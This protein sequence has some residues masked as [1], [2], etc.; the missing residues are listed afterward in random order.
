MVTIK[1][2]KKS[3]VGVALGALAVACTKA[4]VYDPSASPEQ[5]KQPEVEAPKVANAFNFSTT[6]TVALTIDYSADKVPTAVFFSIYDE[7]PLNVEVSEDG[8]ETKTLKEELT[9]IY[10]NYTN[11]NGVFNR[12]IEL[13]SYV[14]HIYVLTGDFTVSQVLMETDVQGGSAK[15][16]SGSNKAATRTVGTRADD[17][18]TDMSTLWNLTH[19]VDKNNGNKTD[20][21]IYNDWITSLGTW[22][23]NSGRPSYVNQVT[24]D[25]LKFTEEEFQAVYAAA[26]KALNVNRQCDDALITQADLQLVKDSEVGITMLGGNTCWHSTL[27]YYYYTGEVPTRENLHIIM[28]FPNT[29]DGHWTNGAGANNNYNG[30]IGV[31]RGDVIQLKYYPNIAQGDLETV[32]DIFPAGTKLGFILKANG[33]G[34]QPNVGSKKYYVEG[35]GVGYGHRMYNVWGASTDGLSYCNSNGRTGNDWKYLNPDGESRTAKF[36]CTAPNN[37]SY[38]IVSF[39]DACNDK[40]YSDVIFSLKPM[41]AFQKLP[42]PEDKVVETKGV[43]CFEDLWP[44]KGDYDLNDCVVGFKHAKKFEKKFD[45]KEFKVVKETFS[46]TTYQNYVTLKSGLAVTLNTTMAPTSVVMKKV[47]AG[48]VS[49]AN[50]TKDGDV[51]LLTDN[52]S[53]ELGTEYV[54]ELNYE[55]GITDQQTAVAKPFIYRDQADGKRWEVHIVGEAPTSKMDTSYFGKED[56]LSNPAQGKY[57]VREGNYPFAF[58]LNNAT[59]SD[60]ARILERSNE[61]KAIDQLFSG[62]INWVSSGGNSDSKWYKE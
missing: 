47:K 51:Y 33:W 45:E 43:Y 31:Q 35:P 21:R 44:A 18:T 3:I 2:F 38:A 25:K 24:N 59:V 5:G 57:F 1:I 26:T 58:Y 56:D 16:I 23:K 12:T 22:D 15:L 40:N 36:Q 48:V 10:E 9:P 28:L 60:I 53:G 52:I 11:S 14:K 55:T 41:D 7:N 50:F 39:E 19:E 13:P 54:L 37:H 62:Y 6:Q 46:L 61:S 34:M 29:Q 20:V 30:N 49:E 8:Y 17:Q 32:S 4:D 27:G 42:D